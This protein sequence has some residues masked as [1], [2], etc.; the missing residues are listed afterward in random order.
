MKF[1]INFPQ[2]DGFEFGNLM[3]AF[4]NKLPSEEISPAVQ[5]IIY[6]L[7]MGIFIPKS[8]IVLAILDEPLD[9]GMVVEIS[10]AKMIRKLVIGIRTDVRSPY[11]SILEPL[12]GMHFFLAYHR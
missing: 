11:G 9:E 5:K 3:R 1:I 2:R 4:Y 8:D 6:L 10:Y 12:T 7:D